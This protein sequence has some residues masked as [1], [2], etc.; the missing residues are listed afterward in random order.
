MTT[1]TTATEATIVAYEKTEFDTSCWLCPACWAQGDR[2]FTHPWTAAALA[3]WWARAQRGD[4][5]FACALC[6]VTLYPPGAERPPAYRQWATGETCQCGAPMVEGEHWS[7][8]DGYWRPL[9]ECSRC[10]CEWCAEHGAALRIFEPWQGRWGLYCTLCILSTEMWT[11]MAAEMTHSVAAIR[12]AVEQGLA[13][14]AAATW[15]WENRL[16]TIRDRAKWEA[17]H[18]EWTEEF[19]AA[20][21]ALPERW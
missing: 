15:T 21:A 17:Q 9:P 10:R 11:D 8:A 13:Q 12:A 4:L 2:D 20:I 14:Q 16:D 6:E 18:L 5:V 1:P 19:R 3:K 7:A